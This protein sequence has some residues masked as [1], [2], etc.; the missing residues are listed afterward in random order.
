MSLCD[1]DP[2]F[3]AA[4]SLKNRLHRE[5]GVGNCRTNIST[6]IQ[7]MALFLKRFLV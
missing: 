2:D 1:F 6:A 7:E 4:A 3:R 5:S